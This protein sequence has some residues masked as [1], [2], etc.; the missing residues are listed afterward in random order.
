MSKSSETKKQAA[1]ALVELVVAASSTETF[2]EC[3]G[4]QDRSIS[5]AASEVMEAIFDD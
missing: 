1:K 4:F 5:Q 2:D 3:F